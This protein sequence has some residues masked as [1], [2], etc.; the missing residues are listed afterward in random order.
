MALIGIV[1]FFL[2]GDLVLR[3]IEG[4]RYTDPL[5]DACCY[6]ILIG[7]V[8]V[9]GY[10]TMRYWR[11]LLALSIADDPAYRTF[12][13]AEPGE[14]LD[15]IEN[16]L[17]FLYLEHSRLDPP[18]LAF[19]N[20]QRFPK[21]LQGMFRVRDPD[22]AIVVYTSAKKGTGRYLSDVMVGPVN[23]GNAAKVLSILQAIDERTVAGRPAL[24]IR[25]G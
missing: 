15:V 23:D 6:S 21:N 13:V 24:N 4:S 22:L 16:G 14:M 5:T 3:L 10:F 1:M 11:H 9:T 8:V 17:K 7:L 25:T 19:T 12:S 2:V 20:R 18:G